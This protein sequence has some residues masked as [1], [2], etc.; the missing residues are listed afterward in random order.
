MPMMMVRHAMTRQPD[1]HW[2]TERRAGWLTFYG[3]MQP[4]IVPQA[5]QAELDTIA[6]RLEGA[7]PDSNRGRGVRL[8]LN[9]AMAPE[10]RASMRN[11]FGLL[12]AAVCLLL[13]IACGNVA[14]LLLAR[15]V[16]RSREVAIRLALGA[17]LWTL[18]RTLLAE[19]LLLAF[20]GAAL[21]LLL[22]PWM[23][24]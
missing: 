21:G 19:S 8:S 23:L 12:L 15:A 20:G 17:G 9:A 14:N 22:A 18:L 4:D 24:P 10:Q 5:A 11:L 3:R 1:Y 6:R 7:Y 2:L 16:A 13:L